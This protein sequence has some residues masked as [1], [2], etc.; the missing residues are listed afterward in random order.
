MYILSVVLTSLMGILQNSVFSGCR[1][2]QLLTVYRMQKPCI[3]GVMK[4]GRV[5][6]G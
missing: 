5:P 4:T 6:S 2:A 1:M 3:F